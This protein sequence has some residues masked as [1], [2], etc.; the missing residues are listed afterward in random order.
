MVEANQDDRYYENEGNDDLRG[1][2][3]STLLQKLHLAEIEELIQEANVVIIEVT[4]DNPHVTTLDPGLYVSIDGKLRF[5][6]SRSQKGNAVII[7][8]AKDEARMLAEK[9]M[10]EARK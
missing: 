3:M 1:L 9:L 5:C 6:F 8:L 7:T 2:P 4:A 10:E